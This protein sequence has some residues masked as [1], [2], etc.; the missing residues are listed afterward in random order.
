MLRAHTNRLVGKSV[1]SSTIIR[2]LQQDKRSIVL[3]YF[4]NYY[5]SSS[6]KSSHILR[7]LAAQILR[8][9]KDLSGY[10][11]DEHICQGLTSSIPQLKKLIPTLLSSIPSVRI[12]VDGLDEFE[13]KD[14]NQVLNDVIPFASTSDTGAVCKVLIA[15]R[16]IN[17][18]SRHL[19]KRSTVSLTRERAVIDAAIQ[20]FVEHSLIDI[21]QNLSDT[22]IDD[23]IMVE[24]E[25]GLIKKADGESTLVLAKSLKC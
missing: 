13:Q 19:S 25:Q 2:F 15:S 8:C 16:D 6:S 12:I 1:L 7:S 5:S 11:Y 14:Q 9:S 3:Y 24:V 4:C 20:S 23:S 21:R 18:I 22:N 17:P 10:V